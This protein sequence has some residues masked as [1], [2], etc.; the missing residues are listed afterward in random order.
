MYS[1]FKQI[2]DFAHRGVSLDYT[3]ID[4]RSNGSSCIYGDGKTYTVNARQMSSYGDEIDCECL[5]VDLIEAIRW[6]MKIGYR[7]FGESKRVIINEADK[8]ILRDIMRLASQN[9]A[10]DYSIH[11]RKDGMMYALSIRETW[12][13]GEPIYLN[14]FNDLQEAMETGIIEGDRYLQ[15]K[16][17]EKLTRTS[18]PCQIY[19][20]KY[21]NY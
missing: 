20:H 13:F 12:S 4:Q 6:V 19:N 18:S 15:C 9:V 14:V 10:I 3:I 16:E 5:Y 21:H 7:H 2:M 11:N 1:L 17:R 8:K